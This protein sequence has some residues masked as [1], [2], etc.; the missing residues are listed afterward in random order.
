MEWFYEKYKI[1]RVIGCIDGTHIGLQK[2][3]S[4]EHMFF[5][6]KGFHSLNVMVYNIRAINARYG[7]AAHDS[8]IWKHSEERK[9]L[10]ERSQLN[11]KNNFWLLGTPDI[12]LNRGALHL[13]EVPEMVQVKAHLTRSTQRP[14][15]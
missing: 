11:P 9:S 3:S 14:D 7:G 15:A 12:R 1:P 8:F 2:P 13:T 6:R 5:N 10:Q 4:N